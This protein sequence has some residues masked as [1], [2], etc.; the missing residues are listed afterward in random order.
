VLLL[1]V[2]VINVVSNDFWML[3]SGSNMRDFKHFYFFQTLSIM[4]G[5]LLLASV[6][7]GDISMDGRKKSY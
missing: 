2:S 1:V 7:A 6:G 3:E 4:G 5:I